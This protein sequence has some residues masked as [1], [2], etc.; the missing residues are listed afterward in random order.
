MVEPGFNSGSDRVYG[1]WEANELGDRLKN[2]KGEYVVVGN[3][4]ANLVY[5]E[6]KG[7][8]NPPEFIWVKTI[9]PTALLFLDSDKLGSNYKNDMFVGS[10]DGRR[11]FHF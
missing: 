8:Y 5:F 9:A 10:A 1:V 2:K 3:N 6:G 11:I 4:P 7:H